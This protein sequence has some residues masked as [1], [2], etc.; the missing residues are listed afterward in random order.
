MS[1]P[2]KTFYKKKFKI[3]PLEKFLVPPLKQD[4]SFERVKM[5]DISERF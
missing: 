2:L 4:D 3:Q 5:K 1:K